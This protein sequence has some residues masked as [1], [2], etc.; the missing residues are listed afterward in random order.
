[1]AFPYSP[2]GGATSLTMT[3]LQLPD[4]ELQFDSL[5]WGGVMGSDGGVVVVVVFVSLFLS[6][7]LLL[8]LVVLCPAAGVDG[9]H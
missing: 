6:S 1:M 3:H 4:D 8:L 5:V 9:I 2:G 7:L